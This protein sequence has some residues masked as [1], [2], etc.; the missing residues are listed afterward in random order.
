MIS[1][2]LDFHGMNNLRDLG[3]MP[4]AN[5][6]R[7][8]PGMLFRSEHLH[9]ADSEDLQKLAAA[10]SLVVD[11][12]SDPE[13]AEKPD[14]DIP[15]VENIHVP[16]VEN[17]AA[18]ISRDKKSRDLIFLTLADDPDESK[19]YMCRMY[20][21]FVMNDYCV[22]QY[23]KFVRLLFK[24]YENAVL[25]HCTAGKDRAGFASVIVEKMLGVDDAVVLE[26]YL[27]T[28]L[29]L[30]KDILE[31]LRMAEGMLGG[32]TETS[33]LALEY[34]FGAHREFLDAVYGAV[35][36]KFG[37][38]DGFI[39]NGLQVSNEELEYFR[40]RYLEQETSSGITGHGIL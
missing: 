22:S 36:E 39:R 21:N 10:L 31:L 32:L 37:D 14:P 4:G 18:G 8:R 34:V 28:N 30:K 17:L 11:F 24:E 38:F 29:C 6:R 3:G 1:R 5:G 20:R 35:T 27:Q 13:R 9:S 33:K 2:K 12:R 16:I 23:A 25:W 40:D 26:D 19:E 15:G 7:V